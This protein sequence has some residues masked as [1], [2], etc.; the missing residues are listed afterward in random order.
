LL[1]DE[2]ARLR[3]WWLIRIREVR[4]VVVAIAIAIRIIFWTKERLPLY[5]HAGDSGQLP[6]EKRD[7]L[8]QLELEGLII[9]RRDA[10]DR[11]WHSAA[12][13]TV[14]NTIGVLGCSLDI[15]KIRELVLPTRASVLRQRFRIWG[16]ERAG[17]TAK[18]RIKIM[19]HTQR[20]I[21]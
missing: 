16:I 15:R 20:E 9:R 12:G 21:F 4:D 7:G 10:D 17:C 8:G 14:S 18:I 2:R 1:D 5:R 6:Q 11:V 13:D 19:I 3:N